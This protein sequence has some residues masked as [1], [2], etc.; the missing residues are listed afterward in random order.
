MAE[1][2]LTHPG[3]SAATEAGPRGADR[4]DG[5]ANPSLRELLRW[6]LGITRPVHPPLLVSL[7]FR[8]VNL[9]LDV[10]LFATAAGG[11]VYVA[12]D[13]GSASQMVILLVALALTK[14]TAAYFEQFTGHYV[15]FKALELLRTFVFAKLWPK[16][17]AIVAHSRSGDLLASLTRDVDR[18]EVVYA[19]T[20]APVVSAYVVA[21]I[22][23]L[24]AALLVGVEHV[25]I[26]GVA[27]ALALF[28]VPYVGMRTAFA[29]TAET[30]VRRRELSQ[31]I[32]DSVFGLDEVLGYGRERERLAEMDRVGA[33]IGETAGVARRIAATRRGVNVL[34]VLVATLSVVWLGVGELPLFVVAALAA[35]TIRVFEAPRGI[36]DSTGY[37]DHSLSAARRLYQ[38]SHAEERVSDGPDELALTRAPSVRFEGVSYAYPSDDDRAMKDVLSGVDVTV[39]AGGHVMLVGRSGSGKSTLVQLLLRYDDPREGRVSID[40]ASVSRYSLD[41]LRRSVVAVSQRNQLLA[42]SIANNLRLGAPDASEEALWRV[43][44]VVGLADEVRAM[45]ETLE[46]FVGPNGSALSG[47]QRQRLCLA[48]ALLLHPKVLVLDE[49]AA[50]LDVALEDEIRA[51]LAKWDEDMTILEVTHR[52]RASREADLVVI[53]DR[54]RVILSGAPAEVTE[55]AIAARIRGTSE[56]RSAEG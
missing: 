26:A 1:Q 52:L 5:D 41:S 27:L 42:T 38:I 43:L 16:A 50:N 48:R 21:P 54:G 55:E 12:R 40:G 20:F 10:A 30:L 13:G 23:F 18:I 56:P 34:L 4:Q 44:D 47:G 45:P 24:V 14:A 29:R 7:F 32:S 3:V 36:E 39:P 9:S 2:A 15:A 51:S 6:L 49:F 8:I 33:S 19:H 25:W 53:L 22:G 31:Q 28:V 11:V 46:T 17:P 35:G 37:L